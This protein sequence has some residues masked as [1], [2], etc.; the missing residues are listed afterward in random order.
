[1]INPCKINAFRTGRHWNDDK[2]KN[3]DADEE[4]NVERDFGLQRAKQIYHALK[5]KHEKLQEHKQQ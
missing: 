3:V 1:M 2:H 4:E 5:H